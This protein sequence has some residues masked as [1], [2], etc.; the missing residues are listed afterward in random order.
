ME[1]AVYDLR[2]LNAV[3]NKLSE[4][5]NYTADTKLMEGYQLFN[6]MV[7]T[8]WLRLNGW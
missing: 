1:I 7:D 4:K 8:K 6:K 2:G 3:G 5:F